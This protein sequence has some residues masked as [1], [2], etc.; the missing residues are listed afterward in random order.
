MIKKIV[1]ISMAFALTIGALSFSFA[2][3]DLSGEDKINSLIKQEVLSGYT[4]GTLKLQN[5][6]KRSEFSSVLAKLLVEAEE[7]EDYKGR[8]EFED[9]EK[10]SWASPFVNILFDKG[11]ANGYED[12]TFRP[13]NDIGYDEIL[14]MVVKS[15]DLDE[16]IEEGS[17]WSEGY[18][19]K[20]KELG[21]LDGL[22]ID[23]YSKKANRQ[24]TFEIIYNTI[25]AN[26]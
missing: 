2:E 17:N 21:I 22:E 16:E 15:L 3:N 7:I 13:D 1:S 20:A 6:I 18:I 25:E 8:S 9:V 24:Q 19:N 5:S 10:T 26:K 14:V 12:N 4:D 23:D 11:I